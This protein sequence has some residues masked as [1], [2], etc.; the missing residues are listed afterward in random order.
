MRTLENELATLRNDYYT[1]F[2]SQLKLNEEIELTNLLFPK[3]SFAAIKDNIVRD[4][5]ASVTKK[6]P[7]SSEKLEAS[8]KSADDKAENAEP[9][10]KWNSVLTTLKV[11]KKWK[12]K[13]EDSAKEKGQKVVDSPVADVTQDEI[14]QL[15]KTLILLKQKKRPSAD[16][17]LLMENIAHKLKA[18]EQA[19]FSKQHTSQQYQ[20][21]KQ[22]AANNE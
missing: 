2:E 18:C 8:I 4:R 1:E 12:S 16:D 21:N 9:V 17:L 20:I 22:L 19:H 15:R 13:F 6:F 11:A 14:I 10:S 7:S 3:P 5:R